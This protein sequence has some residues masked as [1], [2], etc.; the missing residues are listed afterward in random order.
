[1]D[2]PVIGIS[3]SLIIDN[4]GMFPGY[5][6][7]YVNDDYVQA[8]INAGGIPF[9]IPFSKDKSLVE[10]TV[11]HI[12]GLILSGGHDVFPLNYN[13][14]PDQKLG[15]VFPE[16]DE[17]DFALVAAA[18]KKQIPVFGIC[19][20][21]QIIN[22]AHGGTLYQDLSSR[23]KKC[24]KHSQGHSPSLGT[25]SVKVEKDSMLASILGT[26]IRT[27][28]FHHQII[29]DVAP[30]LKAVAYASDG[31][32]EAIESSAGEPIF[33]TQWHPEMMAATESSMLDLFKHIINLA[34]N[35]K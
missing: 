10:I 16:R 25:H 22:V 26:D 12:D 4:G 30:S 15:E 32:V 3:G 8:V 33:G 24:I 35:N 18:K 34:K 7:S 31:V 11:E 6:R 9:I 2:K 29:K 1:M 5:K 20:G 17:F 19:R 21:F 14:E 13:E 23:E 27:N 28:S